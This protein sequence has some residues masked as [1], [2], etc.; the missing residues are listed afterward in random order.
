MKPWLAMLA[1]GSFVIPVGAGAH[2]DDPA[3][4]IFPAW[5]EGTER[6]II[7][8][9]AGNSE[10]P[11]QLTIG[12][13]GLG[14]KLPSPWGTLG[15]EELPILCF[16]GHMCTT[17]IW[18]KGCGSS[19]PPANNDLSPARSGG[20]IT[21]STRVSKPARSRELPLAVV[22]RG[23]ASHNHLMSWSCGKPGKK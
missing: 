22:R 14:P 4:E 11:N 6:E 16:R 2:H 8:G 15:I 23:S 7:M 13:F 3:P 5:Y 1:I 19:H 9:P 17:T 18:T 12:C 10:N 21:K 20:I